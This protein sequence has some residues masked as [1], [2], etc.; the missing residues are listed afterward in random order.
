VIMVQH[1]ADGA[2]EY[3]AL[4]NDM[5]ELFPALAAVGHLSLVSETATRRVAATTIAGRVACAA[6]GIANRAD[7]R[8]TLF[9]RTRS[10]DYESLDALLASGKVREV[11]DTIDHQLEEMICSRDPSA[12]YAATEIAAKK[13]E[14]LA[15]T[16]LKDYGTWAWYP[17]SARLVHI[18]PREEFRLVRTDRNRGKVERP[19]QRLL[20]GRHI[21][22]VGLSEGS[23]SAITFALEGIGGTFKLADFG[24]F[25]LSDLN[26]LHAGTHHLGASKALITAQRMF[27][28]DPYLD[29]EVFTDGLSDANMDAFFAGIDLLVEECG[30]PQVKIASRERARALGIPVVGSYNDLGMLDVERF[31]LEPMRPILHGLIGDVSS[32]TVL[33]L[34]GQEKSELVLAMLGG[35]RFSPE[36]R[37][38]LGRV[39]ETLS[40]WPQL[41]SSVALGGA[42]TAEAARRILLG[43]YCPSGRFHA[44][45][46]EFITAGPG[47]RPPGGPG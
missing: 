44:D 12:R 41:A 42:L 4:V 40:G 32:S 15:G 7:W 18:L 28:C 25:S 22:I 26:R 13:A 35:N 37:E 36:V 38:S 1:V 9:D 47:N 27:E 8:P 19:A 43:G 20:L 10:A 24:L 2:D 31:D 30:P 23:A 6:T 39:G 11:H 29:I 46:G 14:Q 17:W 34:T 21:G 5:R 16:S 3:T 33:S 45:F